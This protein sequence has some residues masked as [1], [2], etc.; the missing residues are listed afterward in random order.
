MSS[1][2]CPSCGGIPIEHFTPAEPKKAK[3]N[4]EVLQ[5]HCSNCEHNWPI[6]GEGIDEAL[7][8]SR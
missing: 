5:L 7:S 4:N 1:I 3:E 2:R 6:S 8:L